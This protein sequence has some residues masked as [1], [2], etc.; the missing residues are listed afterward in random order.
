MLLPEWAEMGTGRQKIERLSPQA[1]ASSVRCV[2]IEDSKRLSQGYVMEFPSTKEHKLSDLKGH[3]VPGT[4]IK[5]RLLNG[6]SC[7]Y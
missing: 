7:N 6:K 1:G 5:T 4:A 3:Q 2:R